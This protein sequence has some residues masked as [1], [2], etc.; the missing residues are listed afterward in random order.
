[1]TKEKFIFQFPLEG[2]NEA[3]NELYKKFP[4]KENEM[5]NS[6]SLSSFLLVL[7]VGLLYVGAIIWTLSEYY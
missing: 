6:G 4:S 1:M 3:I 2:A 5:E 7:G